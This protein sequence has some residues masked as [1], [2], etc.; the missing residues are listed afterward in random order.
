MDVVGL[1]NN[2]PHLDGLKACEI[3]LKW[4]KDH[5]PPTSSIISLVKLVLELNAERFSVP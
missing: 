2:I 3:M 5:L 4:R 1:Y